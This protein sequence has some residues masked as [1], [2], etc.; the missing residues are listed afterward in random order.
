MQI[1]LLYY[2]IGRWYCDLGQ[3]FFLMVVLLWQTWLTFASEDVKI[4]WIV[5]KHN[6]PLVPISNYH[7]NTIY[8]TC[9]TWDLHNSISIILQDF[10]Y[11][12]VFLFEFK[13]FWWFVQQ[14]LAQKAGD[15]G[16][17]CRIS[18]I[19]LLLLS[20]RESRSASVRPHVTRILC[21]QGHVARRGQGK[22]L[23]RKLKHVIFFVF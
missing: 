10:Y 7:D 20:Q 9:R 4:T 1:L 19:S 16:E 12:A 23:Q 8:F 5:C 6:K 13:C 22:K 15:A 11:H 21:T 3:Q 17:L 14:V 18:R 2:V